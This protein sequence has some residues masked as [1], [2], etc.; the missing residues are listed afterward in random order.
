LIEAYEICGLALF[1]WGI[2][3]MVNAGK[4]ERLLANQPPP[5]A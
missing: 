3:K 4:R 2:V 5:L 1:I